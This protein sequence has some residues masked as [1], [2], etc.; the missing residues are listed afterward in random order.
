MVPSDHRGVHWSDFV[1]GEPK[2]WIC[3]HGLLCLGSERVV[4]GEIFF[5]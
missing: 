2:F 1:L 3:G 5:F 4:S